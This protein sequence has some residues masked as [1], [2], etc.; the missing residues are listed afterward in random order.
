MRQINFQKIIGDTF[1]YRKLSQS[2]LLHHQKR[3]YSLTP[4]PAPPHL[5]YYK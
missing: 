3:N 5:K 4:A 2:I 1:E